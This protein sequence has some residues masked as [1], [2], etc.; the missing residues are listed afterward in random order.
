MPKQA[1]LLAAGKN[2][3]FVPFRRGVHKCTYRLMDEPVVVTTLRSLIKA[4]VKEII[5]VKSAGDREIEFLVKQAKLPIK[6]R[7]IVQPQSLGMGNA[8]LAAKDELEA[9]FLVLNPAQMNV[10]EH[11]VAWERLARGTD[12]TVWLF[13][14]T[15][16]QPGKYGML[17]LDGQRVTGVAEKPKS[18]SGFSKQRIIGIYGLTGKFLEFMATRKTEEYQLETAL[19]AYAKKQ[20]V[21]AVESQA[22]ALTFKYA[23]D[24][25]TLADYRLA[26]LTTKP[27][28]DRQAWVHPTAVIE[29]PVMIEAGARV[30][31]YALLRGPVYI[32]KGALVGSYCKVRDGSI[33]ETGA[34]VQNQVEVKHSLIGSKSTIH[35]GYLGDS[36][37]GEGVKIGAGFITANRRLD[38]EGV[39]V[40]IEGEQIDTGLAHFGCLIGDQARIGIQVGTNPGAIIGEGKIILPGVIV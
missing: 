17:T 19:N 32:G 31:E 23:W 18:S 26:R 30:Y 22:A 10:N 4:G 16:D 15:T 9:R 40:V 25:F 12:E 8:I 14:Q 37:V 29:G 33:L 34:E 36:I 21:M 20:R 6:V 3:R 27:K 5:I 38:R 13:S 24:L 28:I 35:S 11:L 2:S 39:K 7:F 1:V